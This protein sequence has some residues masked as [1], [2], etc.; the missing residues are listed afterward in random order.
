MKL[1]AT[2]VGGLAALFAASFAMPAIA[3]EKPTRQR[4]VSQLAEGE[5]LTQDG[6][7]A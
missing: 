1:N 4:S 2:I 6:M 5:S 3:Q 7:G